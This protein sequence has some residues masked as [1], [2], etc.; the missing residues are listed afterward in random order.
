MLFF[1]LAEGNPAEDF[2][3]IP[4][5]TPEFLIFWLLLFFIFAFLVFLFFSWHTAFFYVDGKVYTTV[6]APFSQPLEMPT[7]VKEGHIFV[8]WCR[9]VELE[10][11]LNQAYVMRLFNVN[12]YAKFVP[13]NEY[14]APTGEDTSGEVVPDGETA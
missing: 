11:P 6:S 4:K 5:I 3:E 8:A 14:V 2:F 12:F 9:D 13:E 10:E 1:A 7:P